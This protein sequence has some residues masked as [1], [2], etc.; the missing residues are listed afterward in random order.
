VIGGF[1]LG[2]FLLAYLGGIVNFDVDK[3]LFQPEAVYLG[4]VVGLGVTLLAAL[5]PAWTGTSISVP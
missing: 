4:L 3:F 5:V 1:V 2:K